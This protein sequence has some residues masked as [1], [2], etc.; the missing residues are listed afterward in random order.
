M[1]RRGTKEGGLVAVWNGHEVSV[2]LRELPDQD[3]GGA[4]DAVVCAAY[5]HVSVNE[6][7]WPCVRLAHS[8]GNSLIA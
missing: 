4:E 5:V 6:R 8:L 2:I 1:V 3:G 7:R